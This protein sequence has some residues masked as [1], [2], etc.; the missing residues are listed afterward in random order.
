MP[1]LRIFFSIFTETLIVNS[2]DKF[3]FLI[4]FFCYK[5][6]TRVDFLKDLDKCEHD[7]FLKF[8]NNVFTPN[9]VL[10]HLYSDL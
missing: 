3:Y 2:D 8:L 5:V 1:P 4:S 7:I 9:K 10:L 6:E